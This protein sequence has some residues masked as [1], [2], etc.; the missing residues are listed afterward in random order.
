M[1]H[2]LC[3]MCGRAVAS[4][5]FDPT[6]FA[7][8]IPGVDV[9]GLGRG[10]GFAFSAPYSILGS[11]RT[12][13]LVKE[14]ALG[15]LSTLLGNGYADGDEIGERLGLCDTATAEVHY[16]PSV[17]DPDLEDSALAVIRM[18]YE[19][20]EW[21]L[22]SIDSDQPLADTLRKAARGLVREYADL[23]GSQGYA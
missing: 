23:L 3:P 13:E 21:D 11:N 7:N 17:E 20:M 22:D 2:M 18:I 5:R 8:D 1:T 15:I 6:N 12:T 10:K 16:E 14:R 9:Y 4:T 19:V